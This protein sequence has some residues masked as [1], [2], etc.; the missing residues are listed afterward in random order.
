MLSKQI[1]INAS[2]SE[3]RIAL[4]EQDELADL[5]IE[6]HRKQNILG[7][8]YLGKV[9]RVLPGMQSAFVDIGTGQAGFLYAKDVVAA[10]AE[11]TE[12]A[13]EGDDPYPANRQPIEKVLKAGQQILVQIVK[14]P[15]GSK[16]PRLTMGVAV[17]GRYLVLLP[18][19][20]RIGVS[21]KIE[22]DKE[23]KHLR[24]IVTEI[25]KNDLGIIVR[26]AA[27]NIDRSYLER[28]L[29]YLGEVWN[30]IS[31]K[32]SRARSPGLLHMDFSIISR[33][34]PRYLYR[35]CRKKLLS[36][37]RVATRN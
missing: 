28:D 26:T 35:R 12:L 34:G 18:S 17:P 20:S 36:I 15:F 4:L 31:V 23:R 10:E 33:I 11:T 30:E 2:A 16:G 14:E 24:E 9:I 6:R 19:S 22:D 5:Y 8:V 37:T 21:R 7:N 27:E 25:R 3:T 1:I 32:K 13:D 29:K